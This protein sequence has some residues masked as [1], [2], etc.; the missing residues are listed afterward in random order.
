MA[1]IPLL[2][3]FLSKEMFFAEALQLDRLGL[4]GE[5][6]PFAVVAGGA[7]SV[8]YSMRFIH[9]VFFH[10]EP[11]R[12]PRT[13]H[14]PPRWMKLPVEVLVALCVLVGLAPGLT[15]ALLVDTAGAAVFGAPL[16]QHD[17]AI[18]CSFLM[19]NFDGLLGARGRDDHNQGDVRCLL[20]RSKNRDTG[21]AQHVHHLAERGRY[22][23]RALTDCRDQ[24]TKTRKSSP[25]RSSEPP[26]PSSTA[27][28]VP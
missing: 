13:P 19:D 5:L 10:G 3:G 22:V 27:P 25:S 8:A 7:F 6:V 21:P 16:P 17:I 4:Y 23:R 15:V 1:G 26:T 20:A 12:L 14:E 9:D 24:R 18:F 2:N 11:Q 28:A